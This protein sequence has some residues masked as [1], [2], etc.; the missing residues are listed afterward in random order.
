MGEL[1]V[2]GSKVLPVI[3]GDFVVVTKGGMTE[4]D[5]GPVAGFSVMAVFL[6]VLAEGVIGRVVIVPGGKSEIS[7]IVV[8]APVVVMAVGRMVGAE[9]A[10]GHGISYFSV[11]L[12][13]KK[14]NTLFI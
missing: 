3:M 13:T 4:S 9:N 8:P 1:A 12:Y 7:E 11:Y 2:W 6:V 14:L 5:V 10:L